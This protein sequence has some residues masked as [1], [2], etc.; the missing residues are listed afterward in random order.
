MIV[1]TR[2]TKVFVSALLAILAG[3]VILQSLGTSPPSADAFSLSDY[4]ELEPIDH[5]I[6][7]RTQQ[8]R[9]R[10][11]RINVLLSVTKAGD[12][13]QLSSLAGLAKSEDIN[14]HFVV[15]NGF[16]GADGLIQSTEKW[17]RQWS[18]TPTQNISAGERII[19]I[20]IISDGKKVMP[21]ELQIIRTEQLVEKLSRKFMIRP[22]SITYPENW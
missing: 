15:C 3:L 8:F 1:P 5:L 18:T 14:Y 17:Q 19:R 13:D 6:A 20:C 22:E 12:I 16:G 4:Y 7:S 21:T 11:S 2:N 9:D 10:W